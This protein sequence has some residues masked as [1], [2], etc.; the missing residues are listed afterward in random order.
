MSKF[1]LI[2]ILFAPGQPNYSDKVAVLD[3]MEK[4]EALR[5][6]V[7]PQ[8]RPQPGIHYALVCVKSKPTDGVN[9]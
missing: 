8:I 7:L 5:K 2:F 9:I 6:E 3:T 4:C 1:L